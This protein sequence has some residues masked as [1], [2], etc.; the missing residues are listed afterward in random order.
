MER[1]FDLD[2]QLIQD[3]L[4]MAVNI[5]LLFM[6]LS[7]LLL[8]P[9]RLL[10]MER[11]N[12]I[13]EEL[14]TTARDKEAAAKLKAEYDA[15]LVNVNK[16]A[17]DILSEARKKAQ[18]NEAMIVNEAKEE[19]AR[20]IAHAN[21]QIELDKKRALDDMK[22]EMI[23]IASMMAGKVV[24]ASVTPEVQAG[25]VEDMLKEMGDSTWQS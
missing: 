22:Q 10:L 5:F 7:Y 2:P 14:E 11:R 13:I 24:S 3:A 23:T 1:L 21:T 20:M 15:R 16:E 19:A 12:K 6:L 17:A 8:N 9:A 25:L 4:L 18:K